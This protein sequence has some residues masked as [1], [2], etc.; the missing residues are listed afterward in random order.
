MRQYRCQEHTDSMSE[1]S[2]ES[3]KSLASSDAQMINENSP[4]VRRKTNKPPE[5]RQCICSSCYKRW[6][7]L[8]N[9]DSKLCHKCE[10]ATLN[11]SSE[12]SSFK[13]LSFG[14]DLNE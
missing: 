10:N 8:Q 9:F 5:L 2:V 4:K 13:M 7:L 14:D 3:L 12:P 6:K 1:C 11:I